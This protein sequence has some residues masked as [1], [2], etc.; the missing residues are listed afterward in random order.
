MIPLDHARQP[1][2]P[3]NDNEP[4][5][6]LSDVS[7]IAPGVPHEANARAFNGLQGGAA[8]LVDTPIVPVA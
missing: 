1:K 5:Q 6:R 8:D 7:A 4:Y 3:T 2:G